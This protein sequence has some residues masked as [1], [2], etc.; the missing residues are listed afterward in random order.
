MTAS[1]RQL[2][3]FLLL[4]AFSATA[5]GSVAAE[6][7]QPQPAIDIICLD[8]APPGMLDCAPDD[9][10]PVPRPSDP[11]ADA[12]EKRSIC[13]GGPPC[14]EPPTICIGG[15]PCDEPRPVSAVDVYRGVPRPR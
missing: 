5:F 9:T 3:V 2:V 1:T 13:I 11:S 12:H 7:N 14:D 4:V 15:P 10:A 6:A 8:E